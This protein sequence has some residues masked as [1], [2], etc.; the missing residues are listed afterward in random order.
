MALAL[1]V[2]LT[3]LAHGPA[4]LA[5]LAITEVMS[6]P[7]TNGL[8]VGILRPDFWELTNFGP[9]EVDLTG[10]RWW[11]G[12]ERLF[13]GRVSM[14]ST[15]I[16]PRE[17]IIFVRGNDYFP[18]PADFRA[19]WGV[20][21]P[22]NLQVYSQHS[23]RPP[24]FDGEDGDAVRLWD[25]EGNLVDE[26]RFGRAL[27]GST[28]TYD[29]NSGA[30]S[31][32][33]SLSAE[34]AFPSAE[35]ADIGSPGFALL[36]PVPLQITQEPVSHVVD[37]GSEV[38]LRVQ[39]TGRPG[40]RY[41]WYFNDVPIQTEVL[42]SSV[43][44]L[45]CYADCGPA[46]ERPAGPNEYVLSGI[47]PDKSGKYFVE[48]F[49]GLTTLTS[50][51]ITVTVNTKSS[52]IQVECP[53]DKACE[54][55][56]GPEP[57]PTLVAN[58]G[59][60]AIFTVRTRGYPAPTF[61]WSA[62]VDGVIFSDLAGET[63]RT[64]NLADITTL[65]AGLYRVRMQ[66]SSGAVTARAR[67]TVRSPARLEITEVMS[68]ACT[69]LKGDWWEL[70][71]TGQEPVNLCGYR[72]D[73]G[74]DFIGGGP[75][76]TNSVVVLPGE[77]VIFLESQTPESFVQWWGAANLPPNLQ[78]VRYA[79]NGFAHEGE[80]IYVWHPN[81]TDNSRKLARAEFSLAPTDGR[82]FWWDWTLCTNEF[83]T[84]S[85]IGEA[86]AF[87]AEQGCEIGSPGWTRWTPPVLTAVQRESSHCTLSWKAQPGSVNR[88]QFTRQLA[89]TP[90]NTE[91]EDLGIYPF[92]QASCVAIDSSMG[93]ESQRF[94]RVVRDSP[95]YYP[96]PCLSLE[97]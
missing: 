67:L 45:V 37:A 32:F 43:P 59:Q 69:P 12:D 42:K 78:F 61:Q 88:L 68:L 53:P 22:T 16:R 38:V 87:Q 29:T 72:W 82:T 90:E 49:N 41:R 51:V 24:G 33:T 97:Q 4:G 84:A 70:T 8:E 93:T 39:A 26:V 46:W 18:A 66:N 11:D 74:T 91:W 20:H 94:Y 92:A 10:Y 17:S 15:T 63:N 54:P 19:W 64:L 28:F 56:L 5:Q 27:P 44:R 57:I 9:D 13:E 21:L 47:Q 86:G 77:S 50:A 1:T 23:A 80:E 75:T 2:G 58:A 3:V 55:G 85:L 76:V 52:P 96:Y 81:E 95:A 35:G 48:V 73:D 71:N 62:S 79:A 89:A 60:D 36:G 6:N 65:Q 31:E 30:F 83:G 40:P 14:P 25:S 7:S 34:G